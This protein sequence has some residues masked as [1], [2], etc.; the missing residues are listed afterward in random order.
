MAATGTAT[1]TEKGRRIV[2]AERR[3]LQDPLDVLSW[4]VQFVEIQEHGANPELYL[5]FTLWVRKFNRVSRFSGP[6]VAS[7]VRGSG[8]WVQGAGFRFGS[9]M[10]NPN[11]ELRTG[12]PAP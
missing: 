6:L 9:R 3:G 1:S 7:G 10:W 12:T 4:S 5:T 8:S 11:L 2:G